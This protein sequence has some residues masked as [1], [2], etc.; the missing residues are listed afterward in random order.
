[1][2]PRWPSRPVA[3]GRSG[4]G[5][6]G[7]P[8]RGLGR[9]Q[10][11]R[12]R[13]RIGA[14]G[15]GGAAPPPNWG[16]LKVPA[17]G[18]GPGPV[19]SAWGFALLARPRAVWP[20]PSTQHFGTLTPPPLGALGPPPQFPDAL[21]PPPHIHPTALG[22][23]PWG[24]SGPPSNNPNPRHHSGRARIWGAVMGRGSWGGC[25]GDGGGA[26]QSPW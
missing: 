14:V 25:V 11:Q 20:L 4:A 12:K 9:C 7:T 13:A 16:G 23:P 19:L 24:P 3:A 26:M 1:M 5:G 18:G 6:L 21:G 8:L 10:G 22:S 15:L 17:H 2:S